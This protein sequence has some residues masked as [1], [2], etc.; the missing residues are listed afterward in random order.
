MNKL[1]KKLF[2]A[3]FAAIVIAGCLY[4]GRGEYIDDVLVGM[5]VRKYQAIRTHLGD[6]SD[7]EIVDEYISNRQYWDSIIIE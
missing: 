3:I 5:S 2:T 7:S 4:A 1:S 6:A